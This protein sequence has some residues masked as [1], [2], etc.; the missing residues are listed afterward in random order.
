MSTTRKLFKRAAVFLDLIDHIAPVVLNHK[1][2]FVS[3]EWFNQWRQSADFTIER[4]NFIVALELIEKAHLASMGALLRAKRW[5]DAICA[6]YEKENFLGWA[7]AFRGLLES[8]GDT[9][10]GLV[11]V[12]DALALYHRPIAECLR[13]KSDAVIDAGELENMLDHFVHARWMRTNRGET[14]ILKAKENINYVK[15]LEP[16]IPKVANL[17][18]QLCSV[19]HPSSASIDYFFDFDSSLGVKLSLAKDT[20]T[21]DAVIAE[22]PDALHEAVVLHCTFPLLILR[23]LHKFKIHPKIQTL[24]NIDWKRIEF[25]AEIERHLRN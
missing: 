15:F 16:R 19:C 12:P 9:L 11:L 7:A 4:M 6:M 13:G 20:A 2:T 24:K 22:Y 3:D 10:D 21:M 5:A 25:A 1:Y 14:N 8:A 18:H 23:V 17:Y